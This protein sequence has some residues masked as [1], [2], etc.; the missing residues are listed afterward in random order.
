[1]GSLYTEIT[2]KAVKS[3]YMHQQKTKVNATWFPGSLSYPKGRVG[4]NPGNE[5]AKYAD[6]LR[7]AMAQHW[8]PP[9]RYL[10]VECEQ[11]LS[12]LFKFTDVNP[13]VTTPRP[14]QKNCVSHT[15]NNTVAGP[16]CSNVR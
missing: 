13:R 14:A 4:E 9:F 6:C 1:M 7:T 2:A 16:G 15:G 8:K 3:R 10:G 11:S 5:V 12:L